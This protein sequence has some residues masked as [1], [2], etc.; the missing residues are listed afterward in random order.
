MFRVMTG[1]L[2]TAKTQ[3][4]ILRVCA[5]MHV[6]VCVCLTR[7]LPINPHMELIPG[8]STAETGRVCLTAINS[9]LYKL[10]LKNFE[11]QPY[12]NIP[13]QHGPNMD[14]KHAL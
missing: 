2:F 14:S 8:Q 6:Y 5:H 13:G 4:Y 3:T 11:E 10:E 1:K 12:Q 9:R 7:L